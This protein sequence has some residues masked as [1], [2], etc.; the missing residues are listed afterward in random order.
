MSIEITHRC[1]EGIE[2]LDLDGH[3]SF[4]QEDLDF[5]RALDLLL[6]AGEVRVA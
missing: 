5:R 4:G 2:I 1:A 6:Q 3:L